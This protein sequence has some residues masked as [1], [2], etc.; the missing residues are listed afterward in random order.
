MLR[1]LWRWPADRPAVD[2]R[3]CGAGGAAESGGGGG[4]RMRGCMHQVQWVIGH[5]N[6]A[7]FVSFLRRCVRGL[8]VRAA[9]WAWWNHLACGVNY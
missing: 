5:L 4:G 3:R 6:D 7:D 8:K 1:P 2:E 9:A